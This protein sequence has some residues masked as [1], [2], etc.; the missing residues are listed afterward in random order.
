[1][2]GAT[3]VLVIACGALA[4]EIV[5]LKR[6]NGWSA[7]AVQCLPPELHNRPEQ[8][9]GAVKAAIDAGR[10]NFERIFVAY[11]DCG[12]GGLLDALLQDERVER[13]PGAPQC[14]DA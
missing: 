2:D 1:M 13:L 12:T 6:L 11:A 14:S 10:S 4:R 3:P 5:A 9:P 7:L 8:I